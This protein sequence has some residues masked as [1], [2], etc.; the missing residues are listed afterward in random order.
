MARQTD[1]Q[2]GRQ[3]DRLTDGQTDRMCPH[4]MRLLPYML[5]K[6]NAMPSAQ[7]WLGLRI[8][9]GMNGILLRSEDL[10]SFA[11]YMRYASQMRL[12]HSP[13]QRRPLGCN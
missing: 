3:A 6:L 12:W 4:T 2:A 7:K 1:R 13:C 5:A 9:Y 11:T 10:K 8:S